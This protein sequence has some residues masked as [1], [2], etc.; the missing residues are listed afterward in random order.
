MIE[1]QSKVLLLFFAIALSCIC[2][3]RVRHALA[4]PYPENRFPT[5]NDYLTQK[6][7]PPLI[8]LPIDDYI[9]TLA[10][11]G[12]ANFIADV[13]SIP[14]EEIVQPFPATSMAKFYQWEPKFHLT[15]LD[16]TQQKEMS[17]L[18]YDP[19][20]FLF[21]REPDAVQLASQWIRETE[22]DLNQKLPTGV[23][24]YNIVTEGKDLF[25]YDT[26]DNLPKEGKVVD[27]PLGDLSIEQ[28]I[29]AIAIIKQLFM[30]NEMFSRVWFSDAFWK[31]ATIRLTTVPLDNESVSVLQIVGS[32][33]QIDLNDSLIGFQEPVV[34]N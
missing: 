11:A 32:Y 4:D 28:K 22:I 12:N 15:I 10:K 18:T 29:K 20:T 14:K 34:R 8:A 30:R 24:L 13:T 1:Y 23:D 6:I 19:S 2:G 17:L 21:W 25:T 9:I 7:T 27:I 5:K 31:T 26:L 16:M 3:Q 33:H